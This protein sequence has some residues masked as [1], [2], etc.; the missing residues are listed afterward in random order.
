MDFGISLKNAFDRLS[1]LLENTIFF[2]KNL[3]LYK[4]GFE[5]CRYNAVIP[6]ILFDIY[7]RLHKVLLP[8]SEEILSYKDLKK[9][10]IS[11]DKNILLFGKYL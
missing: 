3:T 1:I 11:R 10:P 5:A 6:G 8:K 4:K 2:A 9:S 7:L